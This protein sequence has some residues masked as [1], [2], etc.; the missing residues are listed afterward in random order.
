ME[1]ESHDSHRV[2][3]RMTN[4]SSSM[5]PQEGKN[6]GNSRLPSFAST[7]PPRCPN[8]LRFVGWL[9]ACW[10]QAP[11]NVLRLLTSDWE[12]ISF[13]NDLKILCLS[14][15]CDSV[16]GVFCEKT[17][18]A[19]Q[20]VFT[21][22][23][24]RWG[25]RFALVNSLKK[26]PPMWETPPFFTGKIHSSKLWLRFDLVAMIF[27]LYDLCV[28]PVAI[29]WDF[30]MSG[31]LLCPR[32]ILCCYKKVPMEKTWVWKGSVLSWIRWFES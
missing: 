7:C 30:P 22:G 3:L 23:P 20:K 32:A 21:Q 4:H 18:V 8:V 27:L 1:N 10:N 28:T 26:N 5:V 2:Q 15:P 6:M 14:M 19:Q 17:W 16:G 29:A 12:V 31:W 13:L 25:G 24:R 9:I 11:K